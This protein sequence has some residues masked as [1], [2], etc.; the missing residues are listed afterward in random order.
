MQRTNGQTIGLCH[1]SKV[2]RWMVVGVKWTIKNKLSIVSKYQAACLFTYLDFLESAFLYI[3]LFR[4]FLWTTKLSLY[5]NIHVYSRTLR[6]QRSK[7]KITHGPTTQ[8]EVLKFCLRV[9]AEVFM[10][11]Q[12]IMTFWTFGCAYVRLA[13]AYFF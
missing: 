4:N 9:F 2:C 10:S 7:V 8:R 5:K 12:K 1:L 13:F 6:K 11:D 3:H